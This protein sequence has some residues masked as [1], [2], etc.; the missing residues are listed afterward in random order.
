MSMPKLMEQHL[1]ELPAIEKVERPADSETEQTPEQQA[2]GQ[3]ELVEASTR[4]VLDAVTAPSIEALVSCKE[5][6]LAQKI[7]ASGGTGP[8]ELLKLKE[9]MR[10]GF[11]DIERTIGKGNFAVV[12]LAR[13]RITKNEVAIKIIDKSQLDHTN[14]QKVYREVEIMKKLKHPHIIKLYQVSLEWT[15]NQSLNH[16]S[17]QFSQLLDFLLQVMETKNMIYI[18]SEYAS[19]G[20]IFGELG[21]FS[22]PWSRLVTS[23]HLQQIT[24]PSTDACRSRR[25]GSSSGKSSPPWSTAIRRALCI[26]TLRLRIFCSTLA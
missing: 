12:K 6:L 10:V 4:S 21:T 5:V 3:P 7:F 13:H 2:E 8:K 18:V 9:P 1:D 14:L 17:S 22:T 20:E 26:G 15:A 23:A 11:Y 19:Q 16:P 25:P 24:L